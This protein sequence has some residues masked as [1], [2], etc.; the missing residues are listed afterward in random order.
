[1]LSL[2]VSLKPGDV[3]SSTWKNL[4][5]IDN[6]FDSHEVSF[7]TPEEYHLSV[8]ETLFFALAC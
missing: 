3:N 1:M 6:I 8:I 4:P 7:Y 5:K 2:N